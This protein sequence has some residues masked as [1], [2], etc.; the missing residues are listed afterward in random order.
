MER[1][2]NFATIGVLIGIVV[3]LGQRLLPPPATTISP[4]AAGIDS[5]RAARTLMVAVR[6][7]CSSCDASMPFYRK[8]LAERRDDLQNVVV[9]PEDVGAYLA[10]HQVAPDAVVHV[11]NRTALPIQRTPTILAVNRKGEVVAEWEGAL[12]AEQE[13][14]VLQYLRR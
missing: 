9:A 14:E 7:G 3:I 5:S 2:L 10:K 1:V 11:R 4:E 12:T 13:S 8:L 6:E